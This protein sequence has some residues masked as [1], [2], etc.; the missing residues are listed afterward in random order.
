MSD[1][2]VHVDILKN[3]VYIHFEGAMDLERIL[4]L[5]TAYEAGIAKCKPGFTVLTYANKFIPGNLEVQEIVRQMTKIAENAG[6]KKV[7]RVVG[8][9]PLGGMQINR[10]GKTVT[11]YETKHFKTEMDAEI[12]L[13][14]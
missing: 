9:N 5:K 12:Y 14:N 7:A 4:K 11:N 2:D 13:N 1:N 8:K 10:L 6:I 3:R